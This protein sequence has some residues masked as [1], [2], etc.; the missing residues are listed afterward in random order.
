MKTLYCVADTTGRFNFRVPAT[1]PAQPH[2]ARLA[3][4]EGTDGSGTMRPWCRLI[5][6]DP[7][8]TY[9][10]D[11]IIANGIHPDVAADN[12]VELKHAMTAFVGELERV[13]R[14]VA[15][16]A[17]FFRK[18]MERSAD[19]CGMQA[20]YLFSETPLLCAMRQATDIVRIP[21]M[22]PGG[23][24]QWPKLK[25]AYTFFSGDDQLPSLDM[26]P[27]ERGIA[28]AVCVAMIWR[29]ITD[30]QKAS[31]GVPHDE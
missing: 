8:W 26:D 5:R 12:G 27:E 11:A 4:V 19:E 16:N 20:E 7:D 2:L 6:P 10:P 23:G 1:D 25:D 14:V 30:Y 28:L 24:F 13:E 29:G 18:V 3:W 15:F 22:A 9:E 21:R 17:D 31:T